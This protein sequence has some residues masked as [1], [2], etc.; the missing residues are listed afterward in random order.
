LIKVAGITLHCPACLHLVQVE[1]VQMGEG[2]AGLLCPE[3]SA[4][5]WLPASDD[6][7]P[8]QPSSEPASAKSG[9]EKSESAAAEKPADQAVVP[10]EKTPDPP[11]A[12][13]VN[14]D[15]GAIEEAL[16]GVAEFSEGPAPLQ[17]AFL[18]L[19]DKWGDAEE[20]EKVLTLCQQADAL[21]LLGHGYRAVL[22]VH[23]E[24]AQAKKGQSR[25][26]N[27]A[28]A[29][30]QFQPRKKEGI[31][32][33]KWMNALAIVAAGIGI[34]VGLVWIGRSLLHLTKL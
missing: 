26:L 10:A 1:S 4:L 19:L 32:P 2:G 24:E 6:A 7:A 11:S 3:C 9:E 16:S 27:L 25:L 31:T 30:L 22:R 28:M 15:R 18:S 17:A 33:K 5:T 34:I 21:P 14:L 29:K 20:H 12:P 8:V 13:A 23:P